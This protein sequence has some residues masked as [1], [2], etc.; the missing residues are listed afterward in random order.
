MNSIR[1]GL[2]VFI[3]VYNL[4]E[5][6]KHS[7]SYSDTGILGIHACTLLGYISQL[8]QYSTITGTYTH[9]TKLVLYS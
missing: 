7:H 3:V 9:A 5:L 2:Q 6:C 8:E 1:L 4:N